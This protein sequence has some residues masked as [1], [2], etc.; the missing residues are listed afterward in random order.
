M[1]EQPIF[2]LQV[3]YVIS[4]VHVKRA[5]VEQP[6]VRNPSSSSMSGATSSHRPPTLPFAYPAS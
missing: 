3:G 1:S 2:R 5:P 4:N 6:M